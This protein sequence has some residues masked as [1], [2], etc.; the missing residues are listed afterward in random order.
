MLWVSDLEVSYGGAVRALN[1]VSVEVPELELMQ[2]CGAV[3]FLRKQQLSPRA[4]TAVWR[5][6]GD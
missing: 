6:H 4:L 1:G 2:D 5:A 3:A